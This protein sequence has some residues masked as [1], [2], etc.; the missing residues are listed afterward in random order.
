M[1]PHSIDVLSGVSSELEVE[2]GA[3]HAEAGEPR[4]A[5]TRRERE[6]L[7]LM[8]RG[9]NQDAI[10][11]KLCVSPATVGK[12]RQHIYEQ[13][14]VHCERDAILVAYQAGLFPVSFPRMSFLLSRGLTSFMSFHRR[15]SAV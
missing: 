9:N 12:H 5:G 1:P 13:L 8:C 3:C 11:E 15:G 7:D 4:A 6:V 10:A 2:T 14:G